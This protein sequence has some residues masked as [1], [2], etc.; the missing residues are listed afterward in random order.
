MV[1]ILII[2]FCLHI[3]YI[4][5]IAIQTHFICLISRSRVASQLND[6]LVHL[7]SMH[8]DLSNDHKWL[9]IVY[10][11][12]YS[13]ADQWK[14]QSSIHRPPVS[15]P[16][17]GQ[18]RGKCFHLMT[19]SCVFIDLQLLATPSP[20]GCVLPWIWLNL[21]PWTSFVAA[22]I[23]YSVFQVVQQIILMLCWHCWFGPC[24]NEIRLCR[25][26]FKIVKTNC[27]YVRQYVNPL[28]RG[29]ITSDII[30]VHLS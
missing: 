29:E 18:R 2:W 22:R 10:P 20:P 17:K 8:I 15:S 6:T 28:M 5:Y 25:L 21:V 7:S 1:C 9:T 16:H 27:T 14:H 23:V 19:S 12:V 26:N 13:G 4:K 30:A 11:I 24:C 3:T